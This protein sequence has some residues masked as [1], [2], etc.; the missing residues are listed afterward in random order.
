MMTVMME[1]GIVPLRVSLHL[2]SHLRFAWLPGIHMIKHHDT[3]I[4][5]FLFFLFCL[6]SSCFALLWV[7]EHIFLLLSHFILSCLVYSLCLSVIV[8]ESIFLFN[9]GWH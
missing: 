3:G 7:R 4:D 1:G 8:L 2:S 6:L 5:A 9:M